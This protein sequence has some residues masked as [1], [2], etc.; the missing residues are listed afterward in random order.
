M[1]VV[2]ELPEKVVIVM[3][4][5]T[6]QPLRNQQNSYMQCS[7]KFNKTV[8]I[9]TSN[10]LPNHFSLNHIA[11]FCIDKNCKKFSRKYDGFVTSFPLM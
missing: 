8:L 4:Y 7:W 5:W 1:D 10:I 3:M 9:V 11:K 6:M 2:L